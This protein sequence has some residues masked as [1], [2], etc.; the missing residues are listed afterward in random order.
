MKDVE[1]NREEDG[2][3]KYL[4]LVGDPKLSDVLKTVKE[5]IH[6]MQDES[7]SLNGRYNAGQVAL[8]L[9]DHMMERMGGLSQEE[10]VS[11]GEYQ[12]LLKK[13]SEMAKEH[14]FQ[15]ARAD[16]AEA[17]LKYLKKKLEE[18]VR[19]YIGSGDNK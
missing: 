3:C 12:S 16:A 5:Q 1:R 7:E 10:V 2:K 18:L 6:M 17:E 13:H 8:C 11:M 15:K 4:S 14:Q 9:I 19:E